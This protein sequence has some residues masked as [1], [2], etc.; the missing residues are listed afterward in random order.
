MAQTQTPEINIT[1]VLRQVLHEKDIDMDHWILAL[2][3]TV[4]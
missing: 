1:D 2:E 3:D 4:A